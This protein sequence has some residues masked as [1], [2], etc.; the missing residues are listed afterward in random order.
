MA[1]AHNTFQPCELAHKWQLSLDDYNYMLC[2][3]DHG[4]AHSDL[5]Q[6]GGGGENYSS[7][8]GVTASADSY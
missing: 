2:H 6:Y 4:A 5:T 8:F 3:S 1:V 7:Y